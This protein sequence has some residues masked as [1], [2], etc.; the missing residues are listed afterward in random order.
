M[1]TNALDLLDKLV[2]PQPDNAT[3]QRV[4]TWKV[5]LRDLVN[6]ETRSR[7]GPGAFDR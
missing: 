4:T 5:M 1:V 6:Q 7:G 2:D 3:K